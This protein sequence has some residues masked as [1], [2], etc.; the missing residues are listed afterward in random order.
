MAINGAPE[1][2]YS[3]KM[4][5]VIVSGLGVIKASKVSGIGGE[6]ET[7]E[8]YEGG[9]LNAVDILTGNRKTVDIQIDRG[10]TTDHALLDWFNQ[11]GSF[12]SGRGLKAENVERSV[13]VQ[14]LDHDGT[15]VFAYTA[16]RCKPFKWAG[17]DF[18]A[19]AGEIVI[20]SLTLKSPGVDIS[21]R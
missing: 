4:F 3:P 17:G 8:Y 12:A 1:K 20:E 13:T 2:H 21:Q 16:P 14:Q 5:R 19:K 9:N 6:F 11:S 10:R 15:V 7:M 18:D